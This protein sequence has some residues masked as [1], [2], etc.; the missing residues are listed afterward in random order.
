MSSYPG[1]YRSRLFNF[2][3]RQSRRL[4]DQTERTTRQAKVATV[5]GLQVLV[6]PV[7]LLFQSARL[8]GKQL[9]Q[10][11]Q[12]VSHP[13]EELIPLPADTPI[14]RILETVESFSLPVELAVAA[15]ESIPEQVNLKTKVADSKT[16]L[17]F[18]IN[19]NRKQLIRALA[20][21]TENRHLVLVNSQN[22]ILDILTIQQQE[23]LQKQ[24]RLELAEYLHHQRFV[25]AAATPAMYLPPPP[26]GENVLLPIR[27]FNQLMSWM[28]RGRI[29]STINLFQEETLRLNQEVKNREL[30][31][32][33]QELQN[34]QQQLILKTLNQITQETP[35]ELALLVKVDRAVAVLETGSLAMANAPSYIVHRHQEFRQLV[36]TRI[37]EAALLEDRE[38]INF[39]LKIQVLIK[40][41]VEYFFSPKQDVNLAGQANESL[42]G[43]AAK[44]NLL[45]TED[46]EYWLTVEDVFLHT[47]VGSGKFPKSLVTNNNTPFLRQ[48]QQI[49]TPAIS[50]LTNNSLNRAVSND[51]ASDYIETK[52]KATGYVKHPLE[53]VLEVLDRAML[54]LEELVIELWSS[55]TRIF[56]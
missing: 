19:H 21:L 47:A 15:V 44:P 37:Q 45:Q 18:E 38:S 36:K 4:I 49:S 51:S 1:R 10:F 33:I 25:Q 35:D 17:P 9:Q 39:Q 27:L 28:Q 20:T 34:Q 32:R 29:A 2:L 7:Y 23:K 52:A 11:L 31:Y 41:A 50:P 24:I 55:L 22:Q 30:Q 12:G 56:R 6:Y 14:Q 42:T 8:A 43:N 46:L 3:F 48:S 13:K 40:T 54:Y 53:Q 5:W 16:V 26:E